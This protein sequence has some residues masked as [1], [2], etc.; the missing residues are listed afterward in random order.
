LEKKYFAK[1]TPLYEK[2][3]K[4]VNGATE[5]T[6]EEVKA[7][8]EDEETEESKEGAEEAGKPV[9]SSLSTLNSY[10]GSFFQSHSVSDSTLTLYALIAGGYTEEA[11]AWRN[12]LLRAVAGDPA[13]SARRRGSFRALV[14]S[15]ILGPMS[16]LMPIA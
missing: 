7:G 10:S 6:E 3:A 8:E 4:I 16:S 12:W 5:P 2:R 11:V 15:S 13:C 9:D 1:F 14:R